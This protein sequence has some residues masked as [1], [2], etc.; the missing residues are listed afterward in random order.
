MVKLRLKSY[1]H[2]YIIYVLYINELV[3]LDESLSITNAY[4]FE[5]FKSI[6]KRTAVLTVLNRYIL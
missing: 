6:R 3:T 4:C 2:A 1:N 5:I